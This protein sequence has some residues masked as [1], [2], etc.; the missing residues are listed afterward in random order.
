MDGTFWDA[1]RNP[2]NAKRFT[3]RATRPPGGPVLRSG[4]PHWYRNL[5]AAR[6]AARST[7]K[8]LS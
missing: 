8:R 5:I 6:H 4:S 7:P 3:V 1:G 2:V